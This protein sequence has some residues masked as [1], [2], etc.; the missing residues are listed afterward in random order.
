[1]KFEAKG[2]KQII[3]KLKSTFK[4]NLRILV[5]FRF[6][7]SITQVIDQKSIALAQYESQMLRPDGNMEWAVLGDASGGEFIHCFFW[8]QEIYCKFQYG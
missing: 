8:D 2:F 6:A 3:K 7:Q 1:V 5:D 4:F